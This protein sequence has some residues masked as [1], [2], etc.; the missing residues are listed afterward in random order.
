[1]GPAALLV[2]SSAALNCLKTL[3]A[4]VNATKRASK[5]L[6]RGEPKVNFFA[7]NLFNLGRE[8]NK[9]MQLKRVTN[10]V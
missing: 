4:A 9:L 5:I 8:P 7:Q 10:G 1:M 3:S 6:L 2:I